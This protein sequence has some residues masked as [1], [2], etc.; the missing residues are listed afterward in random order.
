MHMS[1]IFVDKDWN[2]KHLI[3]LE[4]ACSVPLEHALAPHWLTDKGVD[5]LSGAEYE[6]FE[7]HYRLLTDAIRKQETNALIQYN[8]KEYS[9]ATTMDRV[10]DYRHY[11]CLVALRTPK[12]L[13]NVCM[14][15]LQ[16]L[17]G[18]VPKESLYAA[19][20]P[21]WTPGM[22]TF[23]NMKVKDFADY[24]QQVREIF[25]SPQSGKVYMR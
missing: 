11:W 19:V 12:G 9:L 14:Q 25:N 13:F 3:D 4:W 5:E 17:Y 18:E 15:Q 6:K 16:P 24:I 7:K 2:I 1:N 8:G 22:S 10:F 20:A 23:V 21:F